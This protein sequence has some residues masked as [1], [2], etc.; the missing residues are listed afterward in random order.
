MWHRT[1][2]SLVSLLSFG[3]LVA[4]TLGVAGSLGG[5]SFAAPITGDGAIPPT[6]TVGFE[7]ASTQ[8]DERSGVVEVAVVLSEVTD[9]PVTVSYEIA[10]SSTATPVADFTTGNSSVTI[11]P[12]ETRATFQLT[13][14]DDTDE[15]GDESIDLILVSPTGARLGTDEHEVRISANVLPRV[16]FTTLTSMA[17]EPLDPT[18]E[19]RLDVMSA[20]PVTVEYVLGTGTAGA[21]DHD[22][23]PGSVTFAPG[24]TTKVIPIDV[25][26]D[27]LDEDPETVIVTLQSAMNAIILAAARTRTHTILDEDPEPVVAFAVATSAVSE[28][29]VTANVVLQLSVVSGRAVI[30]PFTIDNASSATGAADFVV[31]TASPVTIPAGTATVNVAI[32]IIQDPTDEPNETV[33]LALGNATNAGEAAPMSHT[34]TII[35]DDLSCYGPP[36]SASDVCFDTAPTGDL[37]HSGAIDTDASALCAATQPVGWRPLQ[38]EACVVARATITIN[39]GVRVFGSRPLVL[40]AASSISITSILDAS[41]DAGLAGPA[42]PS[43]AC[44]TFVAVPGN[45]PGGAG[46]GAGGS[47]MSAGASGGT[48]NS[49]A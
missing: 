38:D 5:C 13:I 19:I 25:K 41:S 49:G 6:V 32:T 45:S 18:L 39:G 26:Q 22:L 7:A 10:T 30:V 42:A 16:S 37:T 24:E 21:A 43:S 1:F 23:A 33:V 34:L 3:S 15:E 11:S 31:A 46:G 17:D 2:V 47:F 29:G 40:V 8:T 35:D 20:F 14:K 9:V 36:N 48:G 27:E 4:V 28:G 44:K 12:G